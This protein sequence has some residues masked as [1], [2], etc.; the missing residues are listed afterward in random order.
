MREYRVLG[1]LQVLVDGTAADLGSPK[2]RA[3]LGALLIARGAVVSTDRLADAVWGD[4]PPAAAATSLQAYLSN[5]R[6]A[7]RDGDAGPSP[8]ERVSPG[9]RLDP[10]DDVVDLAVAEDLARRAAQAHD[11]QRWPEALDLSERALAQ[12]R[13]GLLDEFGDAEWVGVPAAGLAELRS[14][15]VELHVTALLAEG[16]IARALAEITAL[17]ADDPLRER[18][19][20]L[21]MI[22][23]HRSGRT[24]EA[25]DVYAA[26]AAAL[27]ESLGLDPGTALRDLQGALLRHDPEIEA[28]PRPPH[29]TGAAHPPEPAPAAPSPAAG[30]TPTGPDRAE[31]P[32][33]ASAIPLVGRTDL[34]ARIDGLYRGTSSGPRWL[35]LL[36]PAGIGK[37]RLAQEAAA[38]A[39][40]GGEQVIWVRCPDT[41][42]VPPWW[43]LRQLCRDLDADPDTILRVPGGVDADTARFAVYERVQH[44]L[45]QAA[46]AHPVTVIVDDVH[47][48]DPLTAGLLRYLVTVTTSPGLCVILTIREEETGAAVARLRDDLVRGGH[49]AMVPSL[50][51]DEVADLV[52]ALAAE[53]LSPDEAAALTARTGGNPLFVSE[54][55]RLPAEQRREMVP[56]AVG[57]VLDRRL[58]TLDPAV[59]EVI[60][61]AAI[62]GE[63]IDVALLARVA[64]RDPAEIA[65]CLDEAA[66]ERI[67]VRSAAG[68]RPAFAH[69]LLREQAM[70]AI[71]P[72]RRCRMHLRVAEILA[73]RRGGA[74]RAARAAHLLDALPVADVAEVV[75]ACRT[76][77]DDAVAGWDSESAARWL[78]AALRTY[79]SLPAADRDLAERD[80][81]LTAMLRAETRAGRHQSVLET[82]VV[83]LGEAVANGATATAGRLAG[84]LLRAGGGWPWVAPATLGGP[85]HDALLAAAEAVADDR[86]AHARVLGALAVGQCYAH[87]AAVP[88]GNLA[89]AAE[90]AERLGDPDVTADVLL[91]RL[92]TYSG[93]A[94]H[95]RESIALSRQLYDLP[96]AEADLDRVIADSVVTMALMSIGDLAGTQAHLRRGIAGSERMRL[97]VLRAQLR[98]METALANWRGDFA[99][100]REHFRTAVSVH[101]QTE[102][103]VSGSAALAA[104]ATQRGVFDDIA[105]QA[106]G[107]NGND[108]LEWA[109]GMLAATPDNEVVVLLA[110]GVA[111]LAGSHGDAAL[112]EEMARIFIDAPRPMVWTSLAQAVILGGLVADFALT[113][114]APAFLDYLSPFAG[115]IATVG[116][117]GCVGPVDVVLAGL[118]FLVGDEPAARAAVARARELCV[119]QDSPPGLLHCRLL[120][121]RH[122]PPS[123]ERTAALTAIAADADAIGMVAV[124]D[125]VAELLG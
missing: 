73:E 78:R 95:T 120:E 23:L 102:L 48:A 62:L 86:A 1:P 10:G 92:L 61:H 3:V 72:L 42:G 103:Y 123:P 77:A 124:V 12:W 58:A 105:D 64:D 34:I 119:A 33:E 46:A 7:L 94:T 57:S 28:W 110:S 104:L 114:L 17:R 44:L 2:Q 8:I 79:E 125:A 31:E 98:W 81:L 100:A 37:T 69:A 43:P 50:D 121:A 117:V 80:A 93:V 66:D 91:A 27:G 109:R 122:A 116:Q 76:A 26:H 67:V 65:D 106:L 39:A 45:E 88:A 13:G 41:E 75:A 40:A 84:V 111:S 24:P 99:L 56:A 52:E 14:G 82:V 22:A 112:V 15:V 16:D 53:A 51:D 97:P 108:P 83:R 30:E 96:H 85:V 9:Y 101:F 36:G 113:E 6:R 118:H 70:A 60:G 68:G 107:L 32:A 55:A 47:W 38:R 74:A 49:I 63:D 115:R 21:H 87:D 25:L 5:L 4:Q 59:R 54:Y 19:V 29:W 71:R 35:A 90:L 18:G 20:W 11:A 89:R